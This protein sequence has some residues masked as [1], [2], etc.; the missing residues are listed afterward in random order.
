MHDGLKAGAGD[1]AA[2][3]F[4]RVE[5][6]TQSVPAARPLGYR[7]RARRSIGNGFFPV[8]RAQWGNGRR[9]Q[10][11]EQTLR[12]ASTKPPLI[13]FLHSVSRGWLL[14]DSFSLSSRSR[15]ALRL[16]RGGRVVQFMRETGGQFAERPSSS[17]RNR[18]RLEGTRSIEHR[19]DENRGDHVDARG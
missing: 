15:R 3:F 11:R 4:E 19:V 17:C 10:T 2:D 9:A 6:S 16:N 7:R 5:S 18:W 13:F 14:S 1:G 12:N 8:R